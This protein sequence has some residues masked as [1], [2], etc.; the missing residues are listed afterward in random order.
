MHKNIFLEIKDQSG[1]WPTYVGSG[2]CTWA[3]ACVRRHNPAY[4]ARVSKHGKCKF[5]VI[6]AEVWNESHII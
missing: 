3:K 1:P 2:L 5:S 6:M 4:A